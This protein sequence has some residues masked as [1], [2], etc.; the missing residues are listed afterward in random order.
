MRGAWPTLTTGVALR[1][2]RQPADGLGSGRHRAACA[3]SGHA[4][5]HP[6]RARSASRGAFPPSA[7]GRST[8]RTGGGLSRPARSRVQAPGARRDP[9]P[10]GVVALHRVDA[11]TA[12]LARPRRPARHRR[13]AGTGGRRAQA[14]ARPAPLGRLVARAL[15]WSCGIARRWLALAGRPR[16]CLRAG[17]LQPRSCRPAPAVGSRIDRPMTPPTPHTAFPWPAPAGLSQG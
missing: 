17:W 16:P 11:D 10:L 3:R 14:A 2:A 7:G 9:L 1:C 12:A 15:A 6:G 5:A 13:A 8:R 4:G